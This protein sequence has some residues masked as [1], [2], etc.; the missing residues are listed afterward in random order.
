MA[1][2]QPVLH[3]TAPGQPNMQPNSQPPTATGAADR[4]APVLRHGSPPA[5]RQLPLQRAA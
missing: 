2:A 1:H 5:Q 4:P 3:R